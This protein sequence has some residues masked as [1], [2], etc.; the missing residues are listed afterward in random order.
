MG[1]PLPGAPKP[2]T[3]IHSYTKES[4]E[5]Y[6]PTLTTQVTIVPQKHS[7]LPLWGTVKAISE[8][9]APSLSGF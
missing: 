1:I 5:A 3:S 8:T 4:I 9:S 2:Q 6:A 7:P